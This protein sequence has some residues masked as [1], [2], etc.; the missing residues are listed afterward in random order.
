MNLRVL[1]A[2]L[3]FNEGQRFQKLL[4]KFPSD[5]DYDLLIVDDG[6]TDGTREFLESSA[7]EAICHETNRGVGAAIRSAIGR[8]REKH[9]DVIVIMAGSGKMLPN[10]IG[11][12]VKPILED[13]ADYVQG[14]RYLEGGR[15]P[16]LPLFRKIAIRLV[17]RVINSLIGFKGTDLTCGFRAYRLQ[18]L[19]REDIDLDQ[20]W[21]DRY[22]MEYYI[23]YKV[24]TGNSRVVEVP[25]SMVYP[26]GKVSYSKIRPFTGW[27]SMLRPWV[28]LL[29]GLKK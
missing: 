10:E 26:E 22:E 24:V 18:I 16:N 19:E 17:T 4:A 12:L 27:W 7:Y 8:A 20:Q 1:V 29:L 6:S 11:A 9:A 13:R 15:S 23:H 21:L 14:S 2:V 5:P 3:E 28:F 25:V